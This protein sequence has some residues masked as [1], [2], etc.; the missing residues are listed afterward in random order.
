[1][2][3]KYIGKLFQELPHELGILVKDIK[4]KGL[5]IGGKGSGEDVKW[6][7]KVE[8][9]VNRESQKPMAIGRGAAIVKWVRKAAEKE[10]K[11]IFG[12]K[13]ELS[14]DVRVERNWMKNERLLAEMG[15]LGELV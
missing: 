6:E 7:V 15:Y 8:A 1:M 9:L 10:L 3:E 12:V 5:G 13:V 11:E 14:I 4:E 2:R